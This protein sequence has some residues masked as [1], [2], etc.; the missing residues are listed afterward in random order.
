MAKRNKT[1]SGP[2]EGLTSFFVY[3]VIVFLC[4][5]S[6]LLG[7]ILS[8]TFITLRPSDKANPNISLSNDQPDQ[9]TSDV[10][11]RKQVRGTSQVIDSCAK[12]T[13]FD[14]TKESSTIRAQEKSTSKDIRKK[15]SSQSSMEK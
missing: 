14:E 5:A 4:T 12:I 13:P 9:I 11:R 15:A 10:A 7:G 2:I 1:T 6:F 3:S 8:F